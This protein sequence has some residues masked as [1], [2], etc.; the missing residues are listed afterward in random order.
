M[1]DYRQGKIYC[2]RSPHTD[3]MYIGSTTQTLAQRMTKHR[4]DFKRY[5]IGPQT[6]FRTS[7]HIFTAGDKPDDA[8]IELLENFPCDYV[9]ELTAKEYNVIR[10]HKDKVCNR[11]GA[12]IPV[13]LPPTQSVLDLMN[14][15]AAE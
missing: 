11:Q 6:D 10:E 12:Y 2:I 9:E 4:S 8:Y 14:I 1:P 13:A 3:K 15:L 5:S 7:F